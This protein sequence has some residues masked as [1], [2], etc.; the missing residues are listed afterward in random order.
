MEAMVGASVV[1]VHIGAE[2]GQKKASVDSVVLRENH[3]IVGDAPAGD[4]RR[5]VS[6]LA[7]ESIEKMRLL[8]LT[9]EAGDIPENVTTRGIALLS[10]PLGTKVGRGNAVIEVT[11]IG[12]ECLERC[13]ICETGGNP[14]HGHAGGYGSTERRDRHILIRKGIGFFDRPP[15]G[16][17]RERLHRRGN[18]FPDL[19]S[20]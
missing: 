8:G 16:H 10:L 14:R 4:R 17:R 20:R 11:R 2:K 15:A 13:A 6:L 5:Q 19:P 3:G 7:R 12:K 9:L 1:A 18:P